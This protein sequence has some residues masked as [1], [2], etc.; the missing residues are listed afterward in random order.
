[1]V[2]DVRHSSLYPHDRAN[3]V[4]SRVQSLQPHFRTTTLPLVTME[5]SRIAVVPTRTTRALMRT[6]RPS[7]NLK[8]AKNSTQTTTVAPETATLRWRTQTATQGQKRSDRRKNRRHR[9]E[10]VRQP[11]QERGLASRV[12][13]RR[14]ENRSFS[15]LLQSFHVSMRCMHVYFFP[16]ITPSVLW[17]RTGVGAWS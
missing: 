7:L 6:S 16:L 15:G 8:W 5:V 1:M 3:V 13:Q 9:T 11:P 2:D 12:A 4:N 17:S 10:R 14:C